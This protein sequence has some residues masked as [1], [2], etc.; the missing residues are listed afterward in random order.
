MG[1]MQLSGNLGSGAD[2]LSEYVGPGGRLLKRGESVS[3]VRTTA[4]A[5]VRTSTTTGAENRASQSPTN[6]GLSIGGFT[7]GVDYS[8]Q[9]EN[10]LA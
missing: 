8:L 9:S 6:D 4:T 3:H 5:C 1:E 7:L 10:R 2:S